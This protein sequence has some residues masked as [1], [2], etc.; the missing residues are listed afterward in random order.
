MKKLSPYAEKRIAEIKAE[1]KPKRVYARR[2]ER[3]KY[4][5]TIIKA[6]GFYLDM[7]LCPADELD[8][9]ILKEANNL[10]LRRAN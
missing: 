5:Q 8:M 2:P 10:I 9:L 3:K 4:V 6:K 7:A 1:Q